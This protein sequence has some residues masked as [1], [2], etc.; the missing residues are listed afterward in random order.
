M[1]Q[2]T[3]MRRSLAIL[4]AAAAALSVSATAFTP[5]QAAP[6]RAPM[7]SADFQSAGIVQVDHRRGDRWRDDSWRNRHHRRH[8]DRDFFPNQFYFG[9]GVPYYAPR[10]YYRPRY[11]P[12]YGAGDCFRTWDGQLICR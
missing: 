5:A 9:F 4:M 11:Q 3:K 7:A 8:R 6:I 2:E 1:T 10:A 12:Y